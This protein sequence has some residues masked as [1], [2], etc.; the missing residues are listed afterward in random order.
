MYGLI[1]NLTLLAA[2]SDGAAEKLFLAS[3]RA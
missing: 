2:K 3:Y 1:D